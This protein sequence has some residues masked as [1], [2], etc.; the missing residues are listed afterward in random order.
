MNDNEVLEPNFWRGVA[1]ALPIA[2]LMW[3]AIITFGVIL[4]VA[5]S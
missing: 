3:I 1:Y 5:F 4:S 2:F